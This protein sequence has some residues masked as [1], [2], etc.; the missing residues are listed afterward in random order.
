M[1]I[2]QQA[3]LTYDAMEE[4]HMGVYPAERGE[5]LCPVS[6]II[7]SAQIEI[8]LDADGNFLRAA[9]VDKSEPKIIIPATEESAGRTSSPCAH[10]LCDQLGY[11]GGHDEKK[12]AL[13]VEQL[14]MWANSAYSHPKLKP[15][16]QYV[17]GRTIL[18]DLVRFGLVTVNNKGVPDKEKLLVRWRIVTPFSQEPE[19]CWKDRNLFRA[20]TG[21]YA[22]Q[23]N[24]SALCMVTGKEMAPALQHPKGI[25]AI[26]GNA[27]LISANDSNGFTYRGRFSEDWQA[28]TVSYE[29]SQKAHAALRWLIVNQGDI[30]GG[31]TFV[32]WNPEGLLKT[33]SP[34]SPLHPKEVVEQIPSDYRE[35]LKKTLLGAKENIPADAKTVIAAFDAATTGRLSLTYYNELL[36]S[37]FLD[38]LHDWDSKCCWWLGGNIYSPYLQDIVDCAYGTERGNWLETDSRVM[39]QQFQRLVSCR[40]DRAKMP[41]DIMLRLVNRASAPQMYSE[42]NWRKITFT[43]CAVMQKYEEENFMEWPLDKQDRSFQFGRLLAAM[44]RAESDYYYNAKEERQTNAIKSMAAFKQTPWIV[45]ERV[46]ER[47]ENAYLP[48]IKP[49]QRNR[50]YRLR[51]EVTGSLA[52]CGEDLNAPLTP[53]YLMGYELQRN[54]FFKKNETIEEENV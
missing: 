51:D 20:F 5:P 41:K 2:L 53:Y 12:Y 49:G 26:N 54:E 15:I 48:R 18:G 8:T 45:F 31:R 6:H 23:K 1:G 34:K 14:E 22:Q 24:G 39:A 35:S 16:L 11:L 28:A 47:L 52:R 4:K 42:H 44:E 37:D 21:Y 33:V 32:C 25:V 36:A 7:T 29:A 27:K 9:A 40:V 46:N 17:K 19:E 38:R 43:A 30:I 50:Y 10:P 3:L 13:Y